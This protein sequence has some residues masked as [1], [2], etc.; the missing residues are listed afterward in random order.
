MNLDST[1]EALQVAE[2]NPEWQTCNMLINLKFH[3]DWMKDFSPY[4]NDLI[5]AGIPSLIYAGDLDFVCC[6][7]LPWKSRLDSQSGLDTWG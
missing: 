7:Q 2:H 6:L 1:K 5:E 3:T 4:V